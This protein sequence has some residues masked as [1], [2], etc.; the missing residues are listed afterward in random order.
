MSDIENFNY[1]KI[2]TADI[3]A[4]ERSYL[5]SKDYD[6]DVAAELLSKLQLLISN[7]APPNFGIEMRN[8]DN[9]Y[10]KR[11]HER[12]VKSLSSIKSQFEIDYFFSQ[13]NCFSYYSNII[14]KRKD[15]DY[16]FWF[17]L[18]LRQYDGKLSYISRFLKYQLT[19][20]FNKNFSTFSAHIK[21]CIRQYPE[22]LTSR[23]IDTTNEWIDDVKNEPIKEKRKKK[24]ITAGEFEKT[25]E[26]KIEIAV[27]EN[28]LEKQ[29]LLVNNIVE[30]NIVLEKPESNRTMEPKKF[31]PSVTKFIWIEKNQI[32]KSKQ[33]KFLHEQLL[34]NDFISKITL[35]KFETHFNG[36][37]SDNISIN[38]LKEQYPLIYLIDNLKPFLNNLIYTGKNNSISVSKF[39][40]HFTY[41]GNEIN[42][43]N[44][45][46][47]KATSSC[48]DEL[49]YKSI[50]LIINRLKEIT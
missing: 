41:K 8:T 9:T 5:F 37:I 3:W 11:Q 48:S 20:N 42:V 49:I 10:Y 32:L 17:T 26:Q 38:W 18:K 28:D 1:L 14:I 15:D 6:L 43:P 2:N 29:N 25:N 22:L 47:V 24:V 4:C 40:P 19:N 23:V 50:R 33:L 45:N 16:D 12:Y 27:D 13:D 44:W 7:H 30:N 31:I 35:I 34:D 21:V 46:K 39:A 36:K